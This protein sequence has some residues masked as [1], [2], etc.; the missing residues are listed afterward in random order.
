MCH[1][2][3]SILEQNQ[4]QPPPQCVFDYGLHLLLPLKPSTDSSTELESVASD[5]T[6]RRDMPGLRG[7]WPR[8]LF[9][10]HSQCSWMMNPKS[11]RRKSN[12]SGAG[13]HS[14]TTGAVS[15]ET[16]GKRTRPSP[17]PLRLRLR[18]SEFTAD[19]RDICSK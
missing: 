13:S 14:L 5:S 10:G 7:A 6:Q 3:S 15:G 16:D 11:Q 17:A 12:T 19:R 18:A 4:P 8:G 2:V 1:W 9:M